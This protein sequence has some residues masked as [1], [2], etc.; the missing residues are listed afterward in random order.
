MFF[1]KYGF[2]VTCIFAREE[3]K[4]ITIFLEQTFSKQQKNSQSEKHLDR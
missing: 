2:I 3:K 1:F 4:S